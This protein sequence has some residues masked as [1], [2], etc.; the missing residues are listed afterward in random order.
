MRGAI[1]VS[2]ATPVQFHAT[3]M[4]RRLVGCYRE[5][6]PLAFQRDNTTTMTKHCRFAVSVNLNEGYEGGE[7][8]FPET[9]PALPA[10]SRSGAGFLLFAP[11]RCR[12]DRQKP[13]A[14]R[15]RVGPGKSP[16]PAPHRARPA[17]SR[18]R[19]FNSRLRCVTVD[20]LDDDRRRERISRQQ[21]FKS[22][23]GHLGS[24][25]RRSSQR[26]QT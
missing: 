6:G 14:S 18:I 21:L 26:R 24:L 3:K 8:G 17:A 22:W 13:G 9:V 16:S 25:D 5:G 2:F 20:A 15:N 12:L 4:E 11:S 1:S 23:P 10:G 7:M 19:L